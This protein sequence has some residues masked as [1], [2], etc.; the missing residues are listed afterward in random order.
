MTVEEQSV[1]MAGLSRVM[2]D[3]TQ[4]VWWLVTTSI[5]QGSGLEL[6]LFNIFI[7]S[8]VEGIECRLKQ[9]HPGK[10]P[11]RKGPGDAG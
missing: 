7:S 3:G 8:L 11:G 2:P 6:V 9:E 10:Q 1:W 5:P 4:P